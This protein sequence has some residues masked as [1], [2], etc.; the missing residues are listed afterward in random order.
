MRRAVARLMS[1][2]RATSLNVIAGASCEKA[3][4]TARPR[5][6]PCRRSPAAVIGSLAG[7]PRVTVPVGARVVGVEVDEAA[8]DLEVADLEHVAPAAGAPFGHARAPRPVLVLAVRGPLGHD[9]VA[10]G[11]DPVEVR[12]VVPDGLQPRA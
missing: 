3:W 4:I 10:A 5:S 7:E 6:R 9:R 8:L 11:E 2:R 12:V 1:V